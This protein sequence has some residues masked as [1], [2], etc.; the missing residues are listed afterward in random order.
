MAG[1]AGHLVG[2]PECFSKEGRRAGQVCLVGKTWPVAF[3]SPLFRLVEVGR[4]GC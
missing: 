4:G 2:I 3:R 1:G